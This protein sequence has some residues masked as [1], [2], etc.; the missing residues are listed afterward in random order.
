MICRFVV[1]V[2]LISLEE[3]PVRFYLGC[4]KRGYDLRVFPIETCNRPAAITVMSCL[5]Q[6][7]NN[8]L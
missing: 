2:Y 5:V 7:I 1:H 4:S 8:L 3:K 6:L